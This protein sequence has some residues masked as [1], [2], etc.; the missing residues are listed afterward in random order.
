MIVC[1]GEAL[2]DMIPSADGEGNPVLRPVSGGAIFNTAISLGRLGVTTA[3]V[4][5]L[6]NDLFGKQLADDLKISGVSTDFAVRSGR[7]TTLAFVELVDG[8][9]SYSFYDENTAARMIQ[10]SDIPEMPAN[11]TTFY[12][13]GIS[14]C[15]EPACL[16][17]AEL[18]ERVH[19]DCI[20]MLDP[21]IRPS[22]IQ[23]EGAYRSLL[24][25][26]IGVA[27]I[28]KVSDEDLEWIAG[29][30]ADE[31]TLVEQLKSMS[32]ADHSPSIVIV[33]RGEKGA[34]AHLLN[35]EVISVDAK[36]AE[37]VDTVGAGDTF[38]AGVLESLS[39][40]DFFSKSG[41]QQIDNDSV[42]R[43]L[44]RGAAVAAVTI[45]RAGANPP[46]ANELAS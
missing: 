33:T 22:F 29:T 1:C 41:L 40:S 18:A 37:V 31:S 35:G 46:W 4:C 8:K 15:V 7:P 42:Q 6:S 45:T 34:S 32:M 9:A 39:K 43:A 19:E 14:L 2:I 20:V 25:R 26:M 27:D 21:N 5:G 11:A 3:M 16:A 17:Y 24:A 12:F 38:N 28:V 36:R 13:G 44:I 23:D 10:L 30:S